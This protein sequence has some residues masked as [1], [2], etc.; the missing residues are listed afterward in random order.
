MQACHVYPG[1]PAHNPSPPN[2]CTLFGLHDK[3][4]L[5]R[6]IPDT[7][8]VNLKCTLW[9]FTWMTAAQFIWGL[10]LLCFLVHSSFFW[11]TL[12]L[13]LGW[14][15]KERNLHAPIFR[16]RAN[17]TSADVAGYNLDLVSNEQGFDIGVATAVWFGITAG[18]HGLALIAGLYER[19]WFWY[20][21]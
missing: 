9:G 15:G 19:F 18:F 10:N 13:I 6:R 21:R 12:S 8:V 2:N 11:W 16:I 14:D 17:W 4:P 20:W 3:H 1:N 5:K 7:S